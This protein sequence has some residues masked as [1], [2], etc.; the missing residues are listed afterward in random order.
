MHA[1]SCTLKGLKLE[2]AGQIFWSVGIRAERCTRVC[3][4]LRAERDQRGRA[5]SSL[6][7]I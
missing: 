2:F 5:P 1:K 6:A 3:T 7:L 4:G